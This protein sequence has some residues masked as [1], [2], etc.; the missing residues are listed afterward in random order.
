M[1]D[2]NRDTKGK[3]LKGRKVPSEENRKKA[4]SMK[5]FYEAKGTLA[6]IKAECPR[7]FNSWRSILYTDKGKKLGCSE[8]WK[9][10]ESFY[11]DVRPT[12]KPGLILHRIDTSLPFSKD[13]FIWVTKEQAAE[14]NDHNII[15]INFK[16]EEL[17]LREA[18]I[19]YNQS[20]SAIKLR[21]HRHK[22]DY[23]EEEIIFGRKIKKGSKTPRNAKDEKEERIKASKLISSYK[24][25][26]KRQGHAICDIDTEWMITH[27]FH[28]PCI[29]CGDTSII[30]CDRVDN[31][32]GHTKDN[33]VPC[34]ATCNMARNRN[35]TFD[36]MIVLGKTIK[37]IKDKRL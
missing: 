37:Q 34:C 8:E 16:G 28:K 33:V 35:F 12:Y 31:N 11:N 10:F 30:G 17:S 29:Y 9:S 19:K 22:G 14:M 13:N 1:F 3:F 7:I 24:C 36:E 32:K 20:L 15:H 25:K 5:R 6:S 26:D 18:S 2:I 23:T 4:E 27:I 21:Y